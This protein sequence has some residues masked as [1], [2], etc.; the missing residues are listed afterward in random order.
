MVVVPTLVQA[1]QIRINLHK[2]NNTKNTV[3]TTQN[4]E[5]T[6]IHITKTPT[7]TKPIHTY[8]HTLQNP[9]MHSHPHITKKVKT[10]AGQVKS[11]RVQIYPNE[12]VTI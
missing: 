8:T 4:T 3:Q 10:T 7:L 5:N 12:I 11:N 6:S 2:R 9:Q 1:K